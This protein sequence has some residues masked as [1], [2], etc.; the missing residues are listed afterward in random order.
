ME[1]KETNIETTVKSKDNVI[2][3][4][5]NKLFNKDDGE[6]TAEKAWIKSTYGANVNFTLE[7]RIANKQKSIR[8]I[9]KSKFRYQTDNIN[10]ILSFSSYRCVIDIEKDLELHK[11]EILK[12]FIDGGF[13]VINLSEKVD[14]IDDENVYLISWKNTFKK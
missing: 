1:K 13:K 6:F 8:E 14:E 3:K 11:D 9:I 5:V 10:N 12:P 2:K 4:A 7:E